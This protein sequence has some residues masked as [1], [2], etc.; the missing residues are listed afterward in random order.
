M[1]KDG[2]MTRKEFF[3]VRGLAARYQRAAPAP[4]A[5]DGAPGR[6]CFFPAPHDCTMS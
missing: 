6:L 5:A 1:D 3:T 4:D 2:L